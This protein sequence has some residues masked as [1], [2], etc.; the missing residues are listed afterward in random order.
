MT[1]EENS[2]LHWRQRKRHTER[3]RET[4][5]DT[6]RRGGSIEINLEEGV[7]LGG[8]CGRGR[9]KKDDKHTYPGALE[10]VQS[11]QSSW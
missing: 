3:D 2:D 5:T 6:Q 8:G 11:Q 1:T 7:H 4:C 10:L 9:E